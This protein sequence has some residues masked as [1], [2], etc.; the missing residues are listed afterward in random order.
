M[1]RDPSGI[2]K[3]AVI[4]AGPIG[5]ATAGVLASHGLAVAISDVSHEAIAPIRRA[6]KVRLQGVL[7]LEAP[8]GRATTDLARA[9]TGAGLV[10]SAVPASAHE[11]LARRAAAHSPAAVRCRASV[12]R[13]NRTL[14]GMEMRVPRLEMAA[15]T[16]CWSRRSGRAAALRWTTTAA[17]SPDRQP[18]WTGSNSIQGT[19]AENVA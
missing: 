11:A 18:T 4:G 1:G 3:A 12:S 6:G 2:H 14:T 16:A 8:I 9:L 5:C 7:R 19:E 13:F 10:V 17:C 15:I